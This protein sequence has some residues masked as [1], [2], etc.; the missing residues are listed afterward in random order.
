MKMGKKRGRPKKEDKRTFII[1]IHVSKEEKEKIE[2][3]TIDNGYWTTARFI[4]EAILGKEE[5]T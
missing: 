4:R 2:Q 5:M 3:L 1:S